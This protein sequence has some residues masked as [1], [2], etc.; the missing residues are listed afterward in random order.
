MTIDRF[1]RLKVSSRV[2][3]VNPN[4]M[5]LWKVS[6]GLNWRELLLAKWWKL[7][8]IDLK[9]KRNSESPESFWAFKALVLLSFWTRAFELFAS[10]MISTRKKM[11]TIMTKKNLGKRAINRFENR[12]VLLLK[13]L[14]RLHNTNQTPSKSLTWHN[15]WK[16]PDSLNIFCLRLTGQEAKRRRQ[17]HASTRCSRAL[18]GPIDHPRR[19]FDDD[20]PAGRILHCTQTSQLL[21]GWI[22]NLICDRSAASPWFR[23]T[24]FVCKKKRS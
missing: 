24:E 16:I 2:G 20:R 5:S 10:F 13:C 21:P 14:L 6:R 3:G 8:A 23:M 19:K 18:A 15:K 11:I 4:V 7:Q 12:E 22:G 9:E 1:E 17:T